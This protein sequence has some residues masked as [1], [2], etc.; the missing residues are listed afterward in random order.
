MIRSRPYK[1]HIKGNIVPGLDAE[2]IFLALDKDDD[3]RKLFSYELTGAWVNE[4]RFVNLDLITTLQGRVS[5]G[6]Y[7]GIRKGGPSWVGTIMDTNAPSERHWIPVMRGDV[8]PP[9]DWSEEERE[10]CQKPKGW[11]FWTQP[12]AILETLDQHGNHSGWKPNRGEQAPHLPAEN[13]ANLPRGFDTY[14]ENLGGKS[15]HWI[16]VNFCNEVGADFSGKRVWHEYEPSVHVSKEDMEPLEEVA[17]HVGLDQTGLN[18]AAIFGQEL[19]GQW[20]VLAELVGTDMDTETFAPAVRRIIARMLPHIDPD[21]AGHM[22]GVYFWGDPH[23]QRSATDS[24][25]PFHVFQRFGMKVQPVPGGND[26][27]LR[28]ET[29]NSLF[30]RRGGV[31]IDHRCTTLKAAAAGQYHF[32]QL[33]VSGEVQYQP[34]PA[35]NHPYSDVADAF[36][37]MLLGAGEGRAYQRGTNRMPLPTNSIEKRRRSGQSG[38]RRRTG[39]EP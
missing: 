5:Q 36:V 25:T 29:P 20:R 15:R 18:P 7:P 9:D 16:K 27:K 13:I 6:R 21:G 28:T 22:K 14:M 23:N 30:S 11:H 33:K 10:R 34:E 32:R 12:P 37:Y 1:H 31:L 3:V 26:V 2:F 4:A 38:M 8:P 19:R 17:L 24:V 39:R 35:K